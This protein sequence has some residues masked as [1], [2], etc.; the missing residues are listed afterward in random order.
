MSSDPADGPQRRR[1]A[2]RVTKDAERQLRSGHPWLFD[3]SITSVSPDDGAAG[4]LA[5]VFDSRRRF[6]AIG[7]YD[8]DSPIRVKVLHHGSP[9]TIDTSWW[10]SRI[11]A[12]A[13][14]RRSLI[15]D[16]STTGYRIVHG[17]NDALPGLVLDR[18]GDTLVLK[19]YSSAWFA[20]L[21]DLVD[22]IGVRFTP[23]SLVLR[24]SR[25]VERDPSR[26]GHLDEGHALIGVAPAGP[27][28]FLER[29]LAME[30]D[31]V[32]GQKTGYFL[33][34]RD[35]RA[36]VRERARGRRVLDVYSCTGGFSVHAAAG[37]A[38]EVHSVDISPHAIAAA[39]RA[40]ERNAHLPEV[41]ACTHSTSV[42][43]AMEELARLADRGRTFDLVVVDPPSFA[44]KAE[45]AS[46]ALN[47]YGRLAE[48]A[49]RVTEPGGTVLLASCSSRVSANDHARAVIGAADRVGRPLLDVERT[50]HAVDHPVG[51]PEGEY[52]KAVV[53]RV[54]DRP[55]RRRSAGQ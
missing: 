50:G 38:T 8:P 40:M 48:L 52:L 16:P 51:F 4:D 18:Y 45:H 44:S 53:G 35:N 29:G 39:G 43:D 3:G 54:S 22:V 15:D 23:D 55:S 5:V 37:G 13:E 36:L 1:L 47:A 10:R 27:V 31:V 25:L 33:D 7:L 49:V 9:A 21:P 2:V 17:E 14:R 26:P 19:L 42:G 12:A 20:H 28:E 46:R 6:L 30:A 32:D 11:E 24:L 34:Q 41:Q